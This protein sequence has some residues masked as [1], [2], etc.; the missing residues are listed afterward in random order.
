LII[1]LILFLTG[2]LSAQELYIKD[3]LVIE[4]FE[5][6]NAE[7]RLIKDYLNIENIHFPLGG[8]E[9][10]GRKWFIYH[11]EHNYLDFLNDE[12]NFSLKINGTVYT[13]FYLESDSDRE[14][15]LYIGSDDGIAVFVDDKQAFFNDTYRG[16]TFDE[17]EISINLKR[18]INRILCK[19]SNGV[20]DWKL[21]VKLSDATGVRQLLDPEVLLNSKNITPADFEVRSQK[22]GDAV[23]FDEEGNFKTSLVLNVFNVGMQAVNSAV[24]VI[25]SE[26]KI[27]ASANINNIS[28][29]EIKPVNLGINL[30]DLF[31]M[32]VKT[33]K[34]IAILSFQDTNRSFEIDLI[35]HFKLLNTAFSK[36]IFREWKRSISGNTVVFKKTILQP[37]FFSA[38]KQNLYFHLD[39]AVSAEVYVNGMNVRN[40]SGYSDKIVLPDVLKAEKR[41][42]I[43]LRA[44]R[45]KLKPNTTP[46]GVFDLEHRSVEKYLESLEYT[47]KLYD[48][49]ISE[50]QKVDSDLVKAIYNK[51]TKKI[52]VILDKAINTIENLH[53]YA[54]NLKIHLIGNA[55]IDLAWLWR[56]PETIEVAKNTFEQALKNMELFPDFKFSQ[57]QAHLYY[58]MEEKYPALFERIKTKIKEG[59]WE[60]VG[61]MWAEPDVNM[62][63]GESL[64]RQFLYGKRYF[65]EKF[66][67]NVKTGYLPDTFGHPETL[68]M[69]LRN[70]GIDYFL[71]FRPTEVTSIFNWQSP[72][73]SSVLTSRPQE[74][75][76]RPVSDVIGRIAVDFSKETGAKNIL[77]F[78]GVGDHG[79]GPTL[80]DIATLKKL[81]SVYVYPSLKFSRL[82][83]YFN[84]LKNEDLKLNTVKDEL[85]FVFRGC[86]TSQANVKKWNRR[87][88]YL[89]PAAETFSYF[90]SR[91]NAK[92]PKEDFKEAWRNILFNQ[93]HDILPGS[94]I[95]EVY[96]DAEKMYE[97]A[98]I[99][100]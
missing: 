26:S 76:N 40:F 14:L 78:Y 11:S 33:G 34:I 52:P 31:D 38:I 9:T 2:G 54:K 1:L 21:S 84:G 87:G 94:G 65:M 97:D 74:W 53:L 100:A 83:E 95:G 12:L 85:N 15:K 92:Y 71:Y 6:E 61:G 7:S 80:K 13:C 64:A 62:P 20:G 56:Y 70:S 77:R 72:D 36:W 67:V 43:E 37:D 28:G 57:S 91:L 75:Y 5:N 98:F 17:D 51:E 3:W 32:A 18:G 48:M 90:A 66:G 23:F 46:S 27:L 81:D 73:S 60:I 79:G 44:D 96:I 24:L 19:V 99:I 49:D 30:I 8:E 39:T 10:A 22:W 93:F 35:P 88:E 82:D 16:H 55:H 89:L 25:Q 59:S 69:I 42:N 58:W 86:W 50:N 45:L 29:G 47:K 63:S 4:P 41:L 68:P